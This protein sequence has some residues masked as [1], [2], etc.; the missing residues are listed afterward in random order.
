MVYIHFLPI[1]TGLPGHTLGPF[2]HLRMTYDAIRRPDGE[3]IASYDY[4]LEVWTL[5]DDYYDGGNVTNSYTDF[6]ISTEKERPE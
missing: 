6:I 5:A 4:D 3:D 1:A 2:E